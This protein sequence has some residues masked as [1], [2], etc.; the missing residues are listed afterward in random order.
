MANYKAEYRDTAPFIRRR[1]GR[2][3]L[4]AAVVLGVAFGLAALYGQA[5]AGLVT[6]GVG[7]GAA[8]ALLCETYLNYRRSRAAYAAQEELIEVTVTSDGIEFSTSQ[9]RTLLR[10]TEKTRVAERSG[11]FL[12]TVDKTSAPLLVPVRHLSAEELKL[13][14]DWAHGVQGTRPP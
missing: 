2:E 9:R 8:T 4:V 14:R 10:R 13:F 11:E 6:L 7:M 1:V 3:L 5:P 12:V